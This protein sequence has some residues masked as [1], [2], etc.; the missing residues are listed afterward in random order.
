MGQE[1]ELRIQDLGAVQELYAGILEP[2]L[3]FPVPGSH[4]DRE[5]SVEA[6]AEA[7]RRW[8]RLLDL[9]I[10][11][12]ML[13]E[14]TSRSGAKVPGIA[15]LRYYVSEGSANVGMRDKMDLISGYLYRVPVQ[16]GTRETLQG[17]ITC[18]RIVNPHAIFEFETELRQLLGSQP[19][20]DVSDEHRQL[21]REFPF[22]AE[23]VEDFSHFDEL[24]DSGVLKRAR[25]IKQSFG[26]SIYHP[27]V[28]AA[29]GTYNAYFRLRF[30]EL[31]HAAV[32]QI[33][34]FA[35]HVQEQ[36]ASVLSRV[37][38]DVLVKQLVDVKE[39]EILKEEYGRAQDRLREISRYKKVAD[40]RRRAA[41]GRPVGAPAAAA[42]A[43]PKQADVPEA[44]SDFVVLADAA[45]VRRL[46]FDQE[47]ARLKTMVG[48]IHTFVRAIEGGSR[49]LTLPLPVGTSIVLPEHEVEAFR[50]DHATEQS[51]RGDLARA[52]CQMAGLRARLSS[53]EAEYHKKKSSEYLWK[54]HADALAVLVQI[55]N[56][57]MAMVEQSLGEQ[58]RQRGLDDKRRLLDQS[59]EMMRLQMGRATQL[60]KA[61]GSKA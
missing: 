21:A 51:F 33:K 9:A 6:R 41:P 1:L 27:A 26:V 54:A 38:D 44:E 25:D 5:A 8:L 57:L 3:G 49:R 43:A 10:T 15:L 34:S 37:D 18:K 11:P 14:A 20:V 59:L 19:I 53:E 52:M 30:D 58:I 24:M 40:K 45:P 2:E 29:V 47:Q 48:T 56:D 28:L 23:E 32:S 36:G 50:A 31:F 60:L 61:L 39:H 55:S 16:G 17:D 7:L 35:D 46:A 13:R 12:T 4:A 22:L 42:A